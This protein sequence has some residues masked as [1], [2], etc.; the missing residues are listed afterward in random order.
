MYY[1]YVLFYV[2]DLLCISD[3]T[4][5]TMKVIQAKFKL[6]GDKIVESNMY[7]GAELPKMNNFDGQ[8]C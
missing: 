8:E 6:K 3:D 4:L 1:E 7:L 2:D 5:C